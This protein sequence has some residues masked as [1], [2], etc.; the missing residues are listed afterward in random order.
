MPLQVACPHCQKKYNVPEKILGRKVKCK[1]CGQPFEAKLP[2]DDVLEVVDDFDDFDDEPQQDEPRR[3]PV[4]SRRPSSA[5]KRPSQSRS[6]KKKKVAEPEP[7]SKAGLLIG[8]GVGV[9]VLLAAVGVGAFMLVSSDDV[10]PNVV[11]SNM[12]KIGRGLHDYHEK[13]R[14]FPPAAGRLLD[15]KSKYSWRVAILP[16][17]GQQAL[18]DQYDFDEPWDSEQNKKLLSQMPSVYST[19]KSNKAEGKTNVLAIV[20]PKTAIASKSTSEAHADDPRY[21]KYSHVG[22]R[23]PDIRDG[24]SST[25]IAI[26]SNQSVPWTKPEDIAFD[27]TGS[28]DVKKWLPAERFVALLADANAPFVNGADD[29]ASDDSAVATFNAM[30][31]PRGGEKLK[32]DDLAKVYGRQK[33]SVKIYGRPKK[34][35]TKEQMLRKKRRIAQVKMNS[36]SKKR[37]THPPTTKPAY[38][39]PQELVWELYHPP[40]PIEVNSIND[41]WMNSDGSNGWALTSEKSDRGDVSGML[42]FTDGDWK[43]VEKVNRLATHRL[44][45]LRL[46]DQGTEGWAI[47][48]QNELLHYS[49]GEWQK[50]DSLKEFRAN[51]YGGLWLNSDGSEGWAVGS[52]CKFLR[53]ENGR[54]SQFES[55]IEHLRTELHDVWLTPDGSEGWAVGD[56]GGIFHYSDGGWKLDET[57][58][59]LATRDFYRL[60]FTS[61]GQMGWAVGQRDILT[62]INGTWEKREKDARVTRESILG[63]HVPEG[64]HDAWAVGSK[65]EMLR[66]END[67]WVA[68]KYDNSGGGQHFT[69]IWVN[70]DQTEGWAINQSQ[71]IIRASMQPI[72]REKKVLRRSRP[73][74]VGSSKPKSTPKPKKTNRPQLTEE[75]LAIQKRLMKVGKG[76]LDFSDN[77]QSL[78]TAHTRAQG[79][80]YPYSWRVLLL[81]YM[82]YDDLRK[83]Y[84]TDEPWDSE[85]NKKLISQMP[86]IYASGD[87]Y[88]KQGLTS[89]LA[90]VGPDA[91]INTT[92]EETEPKTRGNRLRDV[93]DGL[94]GTVAVVQS[95]KRVPWTK[96]EDIPFVSSDS[97]PHQGWFSQQGLFVLLLDGTVHY[98]NENRMRDPHTGA[99]FNAI[100]TYRGGEPVIFDNFDVKLANPPQKKKTETPAPKIAKGSTSKPS[101]VRVEMRPDSNPLRPQ[102]K[103]QQAE[104][105]KR[106]RSIGRAIFTF[107]NQNRELPTAQVKSPD[108]QYSHSWRVMLLPYLGY[109]ELKQQYRTDEPW[110]SEHN[111][112]LLSQMPDVYAVGDE[113]DKQ[114]LTSFLAISGRDAAIITTPEETGPKTRGKKLGEVKD[115]T[116]NTA[117]VVQSK[118]RVPWTKPEDLPF[119]ASDS[120]PHQE[121]FSEKG[122]SFLRLD[123]VAY[124]I[125]EKLMGDSRVGVILNALFT[126]RGNEQIF[127]SEDGG[128]EIKLVGVPTR[129][130]SQGRNQAS[131][132]NMQKKDLASKPGRK[133]ISVTEQLERIRRGLGQYQLRD[134]RAALPTAQTMNP[135]TKFPYSWRVAILPMIG[136][137]D[138][139]L[140]YKFAEPWD[141]EHNKKLLSQIP[142]AY[143]AGSQTD[144][145][146]LTRLLAVAGENTAI[147]SLSKKVL[148][149]AAQPSESGKRNQDISDGLSNTISVVESKKLVPWTKPEDI[150]FNAR[151]SFR[152]DDWFES[153]Q[154]HVLFADGSVHAISSEHLRGSE[155]EKVL[156]AFFTIDGGEPLEVKGSLLTLGKG[157]ADRSENP[158]V[159]KP[160][161]LTGNASTSKTTSGQPTT[162]TNS[163]SQSSEVGSVEDRL[164][165]IGIALHNYHDVYVGLPPA[166]GQRGSNKGRHSWRVAILPYI[167]RLDLYEQYNF[168]EPWDSEANKKLLKQMPAPFAAGDDGDAKGL[169]DILA[170][171][172]PNTAMTSEKPTGAKGMTGVRIQDLP[173]GGKKTIVVVQSKKRVPWTK[174]E[175]IPYLETTPFKYDTWFERSSFWVLFADRRVRKLQGASFRKSKNAE[176]LKSMFIRG[177]KEAA[178]K[179]EKKPDETSQLPRAVRNSVLSSFKPPKKNMPTAWN[180]KVRRVTATEKKLKKIGVAMRAHHDRYLTFPYYAPEGIENKVSYSWRVALLPYLGHK[181]LFEQYRFDEPWDSEHNKQFLSKMP[182]VYASG[183]GGESE[184][185]ETPFL[186]IV[187]SQTGMVSWKNPFEA[188]KYKPPPGQKFRGT[189]IREITDGTANTILVV[190]SKKFVPWTKPEDILFDE[191]KPFH[192][193]N[194]FEKRGIHALTANGQTLFL[195]GYYFRPQK[196]S[197]QAALYKAFTRDG[198]EHLPLGPFLSIKKKK[199]TAKPS[200]ASQTQKPLPQWL[201]SQAQLNLVGLALHRF[202]DDNRAF[203]C[204]AGQKPDTKS[205]HSWRVALLPY[206]GYS[207]LY[208]QYNFDEPWDSEHNKKLL[209]RI[210]ECYSTGKTG[211]TQ[212]LTHLLA[213]AGPHTAIPSK[214]LD[215]SKPHLGIRFR[216]IKD[217]T[218]NTIAVVESI[219]SVPWTKPEDIPFDRAKPFDF[220][221]WVHSEAFIVLL[222]DGS[223]RRIRGSSYINDDVAKKLQSAMTTDG[224]EPPFRW[225]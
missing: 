169:T 144:A 124:Q 182:S 39:G 164:A 56:R 211:D 188:G 111:K 40:E 77:Y 49:N 62:C 127:L 212:G 172:G 133:K 93:V 94:A 166:S 31:T 135:E 74:N 52:N 126:A 24:A 118:K 157:L 90:V 46:N 10:D 218:T 125:T 115:G 70:G 206:L 120:F 41:L 2:D 30:L 156:K 7:K 34:K 57:A 85:H 179:S 162:S 200:P 112:K 109:D 81:S 123:G 187:G 86:D 110:D 66:F 221:K 3:A 33:T 82:G 13:N 152:F 186:A 146:G 213:I 116:T 191:E 138:L 36:T 147:A 114:G 185:G 19:N 141:S 121:W 89:F 143:S 17:L 158:P 50:D 8:I 178:P 171:V 183:H 92:S 168:D 69:G 71:Y 199:V 37:Q 216:D 136:R 207:Y 60:G 64:S 18:Y 79:S 22:N 95:K 100:F 68:W 102:S 27:G 5:G 54:W 15:A 210:P 219:K 198:G 190:R 105:R 21:E 224:K 202:H 51:D 119:V 197:K 215:P 65:K 222:A 150:P 142:D 91:A 140:Q 47:G 122:F 20:G 88:D 42:Q 153:K 151:R 67:T 159:T 63:F 80:E 96:P 214:S 72:S 137:K 217:G 107:E 170:I 58:S 43:H 209:S 59:R 176:L 98:V 4:R 32:E 149:G 28:F 148:V 165:K 44:F 208:D 220:K 128:Y 225:P 167:D 204:A 29:I 83:Q 196:W 104:T 1:S 53:L 45:T 163:T 35:L 184:K 113:F 103:D 181:K 129:N 76:I 131:S 174:P 12:R 84:R 201:R 9:V 117:V 173:N 194:W 38:D 26:Q 203:P 189:S 97:F 23:L 16:F 108:S 161:L 78:P 155:K 193:D 25:I 101:N 75:Q 195:P 134:R 87:K 160:L 48:K 130:G 154:V 106:L 11:Q 61:D 177:E 139:Y 6:P 99:L 175:D 132:A 205:Q 223:W 180:T 55:G 73:W 145:K 192:Y 14:A